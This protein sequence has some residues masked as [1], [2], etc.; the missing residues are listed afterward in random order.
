MAPTAEDEVEG[1]L[2]VVVERK[3][4]MPD[5]NHAGHHGLVRRVAHQLL[6]VG[7]KATL[8]DLVLEALLVLVTRIFA[9]EIVHHKKKKL[10]CL[11]P[12]ILDARTFTEDGLAWTKGMVQGHSVIIIERNGWPGLAVSDEGLRIELH[13]S[14]Y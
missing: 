9:Y 11:L 7:G 1:P 12:A 4:L 3:R 2:Y 8:Q 14:D 10:W 5:G 13:S 6:H